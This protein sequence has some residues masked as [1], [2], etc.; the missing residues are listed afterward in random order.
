M[1]LRFKNIILYLVSLHEFLCFGYDFVILKTRYLK[2]DAR[3][4]DNCPA[5]C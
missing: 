1:T 2:M 5:L 3:H 4:L